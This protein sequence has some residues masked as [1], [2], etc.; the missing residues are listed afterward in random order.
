M[1][2]QAF[3]GKFFIFYVKIICYIIFKKSVHDIYGYAKHEI[4][5]FIYI[6]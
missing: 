1:I 2:L 6:I 3:V 4:L 5:H